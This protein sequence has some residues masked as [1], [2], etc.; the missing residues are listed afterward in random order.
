[1]LLKK[2]STGKQECIRY[3]DSDC[4]GDLEKH[5]F[6]TRYIFTLAQAHVSWRSILQ[7]TVALFTTEVE[8]IAMT[9]AIN[10]AVWLQRLLGNLGIE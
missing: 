8:Y 10:E 2:D 4:A 1:M 6:T 7:F 5:Q 3:V 9:E